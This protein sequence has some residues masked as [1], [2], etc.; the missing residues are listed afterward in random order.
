MLSLVFG[1]WTV[2]IEP[3]LH[4]K[5]LTSMATIMTTCPMKIGHPNVDFDR[6][7]EIGWSHWDPIGLLGVTGG[8]KGQPYEDEYDRY[9]YNASQMLK[10][11]CSVADVADY[12]FL[13]QS[14]YMQIGPKE[15]T[16]TIRAKLIGVAQAISDDKHIWKNSET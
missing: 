2:W 3:K 13:V 16:D 1:P 6:L 8:W 9:L 4:V 10:N 12:L 5:W 7:R 11:N 14:Q 15:I